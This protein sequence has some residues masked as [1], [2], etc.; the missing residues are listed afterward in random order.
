MSPNLI[1]VRKIFRF[2]FGEGG[3][4]ELTILVLEK[5]NF[6]F[7]DI[8]PNFIKSIGTTWARPPLPLPIF[9]H[10]YLKESHCSC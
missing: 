5:K 9:T 7:K 4:L 8:L 3:G 10:L 2:S 1:G 6:F